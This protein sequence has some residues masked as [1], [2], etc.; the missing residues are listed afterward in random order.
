LKVFKRLILVGVILTL[1]IVL[2]GCG[3]IPCAGTSLF[4]NINDNW[5]YEVYVDGAFWSYTNWSGDVTLYNLSLG[6]H[7]IYVISEDW[8]YD[9]TVTAY[10]NCGYNSININVF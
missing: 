5:E 8:L 7:T 1:L 2:T 10:I 6:Y 4:I 9:A 3:V